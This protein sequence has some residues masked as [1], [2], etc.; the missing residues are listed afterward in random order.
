[1]IHLAEARVFVKARND[2]L[3]VSYT[4]LGSMTA[5]QDAAVFFD[6]KCV[7]NIDRILRQF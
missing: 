5:L 1:M 4:T 7:T 3:V 6:K 2:K